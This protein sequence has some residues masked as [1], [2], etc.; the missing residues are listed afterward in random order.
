MDKINE[1]YNT[2]GIFE[3]EARKPYS[4]PEIV[5]EL[6]LEVRVGSPFSG[7]DPLNMPDD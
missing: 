7:P 4:P 2:E 5:I 3:E 1:L 6:E